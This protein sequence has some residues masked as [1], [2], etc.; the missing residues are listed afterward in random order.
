[1]LA[2]SFRKQ[3]QSSDESYVVMDSIHQALMLTRISSC[4]NGLA[5]I[6][7]RIRY[8]GA[9]HSVISKLLHDAGFRVA[10]KS[11]SEIVQSM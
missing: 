3:E 9:K 8:S 2:L 7:C 4:F 6:I 10:V 1:M 5:A 11:S